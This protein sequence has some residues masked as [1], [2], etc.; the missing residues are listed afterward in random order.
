MT[1]EISV[2]PNR[3]SRRDRALLYFVAIFIASQLATTTVFGKAVASSCVIEV[4]TEAFAPE[5]L[6]ERDDVPVD[7]AAALGHLQRASVEWNVP[8]E[9]DREETEKAAEAAWWAARRIF[10][11]PTKSQPN[12]TF[13]S[14]NDL[15]TS[16]L[17]RV[18]TSTQ[19]SGLI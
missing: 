19:V 5:I 8:F 11:F 9:R 14:R 1:R 6:R 17:G 15:N 10:P 4:A 12:R 3:P 7:A 2:R 16:H 18:L 13:L